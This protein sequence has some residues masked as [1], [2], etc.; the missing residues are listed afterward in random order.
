MYGWFSK[1]TDDVKQGRVKDLTSA[2]TFILKHFSSNI[3]PLRMTNQFIIDVS[4]PILTV[5]NHFESETPNIFDRFGT[6]VNF[7]TTFLAK[8]LKNGGLEEGEDT[9]TP[10][11]LLNINVRDRS[12][13]LSNKEIYVG[14]KVEAF[15][16]QLGLTKQSTELIPWFDQVRAFYC[17]ALEKAQKY[18]RP[19]LTSKLLKYCDVFDP[20]IFFAT[21]LDDLKKKFQYISEKFPNVISMPEIPSVL[22]A[23]A[24]LKGRSKAKEAA[25]LFTPAKFFSTLLRWQDGQYKL[26]GKLGC[27]ILVIYGSSTSAERDFSLMVNSLPF[28]GVFNAL[29]FSCF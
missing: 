26:I 16:T 6:I 11:Q 13:Q 18:F 21:P 8:F 22:D 7:F 1:L 17:E 25:T 29:F 4:S 23:V 14:P 28:I 9:V 20:K 10:K 19:S 12:L 3:I 2:E 15:L 24:S 27:A 5:I